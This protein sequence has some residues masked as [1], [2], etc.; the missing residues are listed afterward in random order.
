MN[1]TLTAPD[2]S[3]PTTEENLSGAQRAAELRAYEEKRNITVTAR[4]TGRTLYT[5]YA[6]APDAATTAD[7]MAAAAPG[8]E[9]VSVKDYWDFQLALRNGRYALLC[10]IHG[11]VHPIHKKSEAEAPDTRLR[12]WCTSCAAAIVPPHAD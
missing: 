5:A 6:D 12:L 11:E 2:G 10:T 1:Y 9:V 3:A 4:A 8:W 7:R